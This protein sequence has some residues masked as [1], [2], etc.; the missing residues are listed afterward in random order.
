MNREAPQA[1]VHGVEE[2]QSGLS[3]WEHRHATSTAALLK[4][5]C[6]C[7]L[8]TQSFLTLCDPM[9]C[10]L[11]G[12]SIHGILQVRI[13]EWNTIPFSRGS[14]WPRDRSKV[15]CIAGRFFAIWAT[16]KTPVV[17]QTV[18]VCLQCR[19]PGFNLRVGKIS[20]RYHF[21]IF[22]CIAH[23]YYLSII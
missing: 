3:D 6:V 23:V 21:C 14:S 13:L 15:S 11:S 12:S 18:K 9:N 1:T 20:Q 4:F 7:G 17:A 8:V 5:T 10:S 22:L 19:I 2:S 16:G